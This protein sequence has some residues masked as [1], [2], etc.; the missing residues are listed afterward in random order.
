MTTKRVSPKNYYFMDNELNTTS[1]IGA[2][3]QKKKEEYQTELTRI[4][5]AELTP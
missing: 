1:F 3:F 4:M 5:K 2:E